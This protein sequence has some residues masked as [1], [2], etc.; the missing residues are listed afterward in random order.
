[1]YLEIVLF[2][3]TARVVYK[4]TLNINCIIVT[5][6]DAIFQNNLFPADIFPF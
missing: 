1:M 5:S 3:Y 6:A 2:E 4:K